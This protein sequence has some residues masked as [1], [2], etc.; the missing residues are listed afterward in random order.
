L[1]SASSADFPTIVRHPRLVPYRTLLVDLLGSGFSDRPD[2][3]SFTLHAHAATI[4]RL[5]DH[6]TLH[7]CRLVGHSFG[8][9]V[10]ITLAATRPDLV[11]GLVVAEPNLEPEDATLSRTI[12]DQTEET[13]VATGH[14]AV[15]AQAE[16]WAAET[17][18]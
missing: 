11:A 17:P 9:S 13:Y 12:A 5:L 1:G 14:A 15:V 18:A 4:A 6:L 3:F 2:A 8:G 16:A 10:A 7:S